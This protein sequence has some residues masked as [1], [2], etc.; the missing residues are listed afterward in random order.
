MGGFDGS[1]DGAESDRFDSMNEN[2]ASA[3]D[4][5][6]MS[7]PMAPIKQIKTENVD[8]RSNT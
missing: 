6:N 1:I 3:I 5:R 7:N 8:D 4:Q 2:I